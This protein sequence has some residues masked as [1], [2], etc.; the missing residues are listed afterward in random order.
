MDPFLALV[1]ALGRHDVRYVVMGVWAANYYAQAARFVLHTEDRDLFLPADAENLVRCWSAC[2][3]AGFELWSGDEPLD[4]PRDHWLAGRVVERRAAV[5]ASDRNGLEVDLSLVMADFD[6]E[7]VWRERRIF[8]VEAVEIPVASL[9]HIVTSKKT[10]GRDKDR[11]FLATYREAIE[12]LL[13]REQS[14]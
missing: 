3:D 7:T 13:R 8:T 2:E 6:F 5:R 1:R 11:L 4:S 12:E 10:L 9:L 14:D